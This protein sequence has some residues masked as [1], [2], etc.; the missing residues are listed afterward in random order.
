[1]S[2]KTDN[3]ELLDDILAT[4]ADFREMLLDTTLRQVRHRRRFRRAR[5]AA[6]VVAAL[7]LLGILFWPKN[8]KQNPI[9]VAPPTKKVVEQSYTLVTTQ[10]L[11]PDHV[12]QTHSFGAP[13]IITSKATVEIVQTTA[14]NFH[15]IDDEQLLALTADHPAILIR[16]GPHSEKL[17]FANPDDQNGFPAN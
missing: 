1:M 14:G 16:T 9:A 2:R 4:S 12:V 7:A 5:N 15:L 6:G 17:V 3:E 11:S 10:P 8:A 13:Q